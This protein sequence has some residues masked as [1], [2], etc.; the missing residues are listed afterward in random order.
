[1]KKQE[2]KDKKNKYMRYKKNKERDQIKK[3]K[4]I[5]KLSEDKRREK[6]KKKKLK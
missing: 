6:R 1:M 2:N 5:F 4:L 3:N